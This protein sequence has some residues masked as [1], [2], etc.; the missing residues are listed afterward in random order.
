MRA[1]EETLWKHQHRHE[2]VNPGVVRYGLALISS[3]Y[4][5]GV[6]HP[7]PAADPPSPG[8]TIGG[9]PGAPISVRVVVTERRELKSLPEVLALEAASKT[10]RVA[11]AKTKGERA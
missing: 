9:T 8:L 4:R 3:D 11:P 2:L 10:N 1:R 5:V 6:E 7:A